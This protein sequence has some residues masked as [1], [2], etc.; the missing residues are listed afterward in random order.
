M[1][2][3][4]FLSLL[5]IVLAIS[6]CGGKKEN[7]DTKKDSIPEAVT[8]AFNKEYPTA[9]NVVWEI[10]DDVFEV[11]FTISGKELEASFDKTGKSLT[12]NDGENEVE[13]N[14]ADL[15]QGIKDDIESRYPGA[16]LLEADEIKLEDGSITYD[17]EIEHNG[18]VFEVMYDSDAKFL[19][20][21][22]DDDDNNEVDD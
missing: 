5:L 10:E 15:S 18:E 6:S 19:G 11:E 17:V 14:P 12:D 1:K 16:E 22:E 2:T 4:N 13:I 9:K 21:E 3:I 7:N 8:Q 20:I